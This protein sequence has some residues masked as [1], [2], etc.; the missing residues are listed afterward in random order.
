MK[1][2]GITINLQLSWAEQFKHMETKIKQ[3]AGILGPRKAST[4]AK[5]IAQGVSTLPKILYPLQFYSLSREQHGVLTGLLTRPLRTAKS[6]S[7]PVSRSSRRQQHRSIHHISDIATH[8][9]HVS[10]R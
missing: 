10:Y 3:V 2:L 9:Q 4:L 5:S 7:V 6:V 8:T 1:S